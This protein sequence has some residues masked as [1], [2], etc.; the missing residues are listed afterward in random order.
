MG[1]L[2]PV[3]L[4]HPRG[5]THPRHQDGD[6]GEAE[7]DGQAALLHA[8]GQGAQDDGRRQQQ[9]DRGGGGRRPP[10]GDEGQHHQEGDRLERPVG[11]VGPVRRRD[12]DGGVAQEHGHGAQQ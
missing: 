11:P 2:P 3:R 1:A 7:R 9:G 8:D 4:H 10:P 12:A 6:Q 5:H